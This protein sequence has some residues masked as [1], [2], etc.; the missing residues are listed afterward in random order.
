MEEEQEG[1]GET[2]QEEAGSLTPDQVKELLARVAALETDN[3]TLKGR[4][5]ETNGESAGRRKKIETIE[6]QQQRLVETND[7][8]ESELAAAKE[9]VSAMTAEMKSYKDRDEAERVAVLESLPAERRDA[10][11]GLTADQLRVIAETLKV[12]PGTGA[13]TEEVVEQPAAGASQGQRKA[14]TGVAGGNVA[15]P[16]SMVE[17]AIASGDTAAINK[18]FDEYAKKGR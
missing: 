13:K 15:D 14:T 18:A 2:Q 6:E 4:V 12:A 8:L 7:R 1:A 9:Q 17:A 10:F 16:M 11:K 3:A 5:K